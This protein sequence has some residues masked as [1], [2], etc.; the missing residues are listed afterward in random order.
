M[1]DALARRVVDIIAG[2]DLHRDRDT[3]EIDCRSP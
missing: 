1:T 2:E 3:A